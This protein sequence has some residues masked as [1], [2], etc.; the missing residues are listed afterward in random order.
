MF[1]SP[2][3]FPQKI[4]VFVN[5]HHFRVFYLEASAPELKFASNFMEIGFKLAKI[6]CKKNWGDDAGASA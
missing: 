1:A 5:I 3:V 4:I 6:E 2:L